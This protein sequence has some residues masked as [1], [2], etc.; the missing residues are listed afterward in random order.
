PQRSRTSLGMNTTTSST[1]SPRSK[2]CSCSGA[3]T[4]IESAAAKRQPPRLSRGAAACSPAVRERLRCLRQVAQ[5]EGQDAAVLEILDLVQGI[6]A[7]DDLDGLAAAIGPGDADAD[8]HARLQAGR[9]A[10]DVEGL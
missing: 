5:D 9:E 8:V 2:I 6:D 3:R 4:M 1:L 10:G 7:A